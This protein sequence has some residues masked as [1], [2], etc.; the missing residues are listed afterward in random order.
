[1]TINFPDIVVLAILLVIVVSLFSGLYYM[2]HDRGQSTRAVKAL[3][4][5]IAISLI[6]F[7]VL[8][9]GYWTGWLHPHGLLPPH[10]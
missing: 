4:L 6:L 9:I 7:A 8:M 3:T 5:R 10:R 1:M 2:L